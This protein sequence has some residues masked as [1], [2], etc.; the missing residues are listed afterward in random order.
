MLSWFRRFKAGWDFANAAAKKQELLGNEVPTKTKIAGLAIMDGIRT[1][2][3]VCRRCFTIFVPREYEF[4]ERFQVRS[5]LRIPDSEPDPMFCHACFTS[6][7][8][9]INHQWTN[10]GTSN[11]SPT[12][13]AL[14]HLIAGD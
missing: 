3:P 4:A 5:I 7:M 1:R 2:K 6:V 12:N 9:E 14:K 8:Q 10:V 11:S 13:L